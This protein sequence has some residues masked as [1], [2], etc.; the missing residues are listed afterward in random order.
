[1]VS[2]LEDN[3]A[4]I[5]PRYSKLA[6]TMHWGFVLLFAYGVFKQVDSITELADPSLFRLEIIFAGVFAIL[7]L[8]RFAY[9]K[10]TQ[11]SALPEN[12]SQLQK[13]A[14][15]FVHFGMYVSLGSIALTG[16]A[17]GGLYK[18][19]LQEEGL[20][21]EAV[22]SIHEFSVSATYWLVA[23]HILGAI[24]HRIKNDG[25]WSAMVPFSKESS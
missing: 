24:F 3:N 7:L 4:E 9:M 23:I 13:I 6:K 20:I 25:V 14:A 11:R 18:L 15:K 8:A 17:I 12:T 5:R 19:G 21:M 1:M 2:H 16:L 22:I 10:K